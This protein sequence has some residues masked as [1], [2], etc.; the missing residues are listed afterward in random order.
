MMKMMR[1]IVKKAI[2][3]FLIIELFILSTYL[4]SSVL[5]FNIEVAF[6]SSLFI[7]LGSS[8]AYKRMI[9]SKIDANIAHDKRE[10]LDEI[11]DPHGL[12]DDDFEINDAPYEELDLKA[13]VKEEKAKV[14]VL[15]LKNIKHGVSG[16]I[17]LF[18]IVPYIFLVFGFVALKNNELLTLWYYLPSLFLGIIAGAFISKESIS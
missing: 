18:R 15:S 2:S 11:E 12:Y 1:I 8:F 16:S 14:K 7:I 6:L 3:L 13:I 9:S 4:I 17:S 5:F 10:L